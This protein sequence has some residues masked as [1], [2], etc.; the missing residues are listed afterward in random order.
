MSRR[1]SAAVGPTRR[2]D[3]CG[4]SAAF[5]RRGFCRVAD[6]AAAGLARAGGF[7]AAKAGHTGRDGDVDVANF[8]HFGRCATGSGGPFTQRCYDA[9]VD[10]DTDTDLTGFA[11]LSACFTA[12]G[13]PCSRNYCDADFDGDGDVDVADF[14]AFS[15]CFTGPR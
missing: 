14:S 10:G 15:V 12:S 9:D 13:N 5:A 2:R 3:P 8:A 1:C 6:S 11:T 7:R 4:A